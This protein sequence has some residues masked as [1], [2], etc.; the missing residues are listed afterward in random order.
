MKQNK[1]KM[2]T[3]IREPIRLSQALTISGFTISGNFVIYTEDVKIGNQKY[4]L[5]YD[6]ESEYL[7]SEREVKSAI[8]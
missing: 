5:V 2:E 6:S 4:W 8:N 3:V 7:I 1:E